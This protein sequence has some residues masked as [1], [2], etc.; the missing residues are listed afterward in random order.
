MEDA[1]FIGKHLGAIPLT[2]QVAEARWNTPGVR[3]A[4]AQPGTATGTAGALLNDP[5]QVV[6]YNAAI[7]PNTGVLT[8]GYQKEVVLVP[9]LQKSG[10]GAMA[11]YGF[12]KSTKPGDMYEHGGPSNHDQHYKD[13]SDTPNYM[14]L[15]AL[16]QNADGTTTPV[17]VLDVIAAGDPDL[18]GPLPDWLTQQL[19][20]DVG[21]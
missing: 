6:R 2:P 18:G 10:R 5:D 9:G 11:Q 20:G 3:Q 19:R 17:D 15:Q 21:A 14:G 13:Y 4:L 12:R 7:G 16:R 8:D 1:V